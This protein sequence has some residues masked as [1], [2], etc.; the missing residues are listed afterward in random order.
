MNKP[1]PMIQSKLAALNTAYRQTIYEVFT[2]EGIIQLRVNVKSFALDQLLQQ[3][4]QT[5][6]ALI[7]ASN[8]Y[9]EPLSTQENHKRNEA[10]AADLKRRAINLLS[11]VGRDESGQWSPE[12]S[13]F[14]MGINRAD[15]IEIGKKYSQNAILY[16]E[17]GNPPELLWLFG[18]GTMIRDE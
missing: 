10:L 8:P 9:S 14:V 6:Y 16:G 3:Y 18:G 17:I 13:L 4:Q 1:S 11:A 5:T 15:A 2:E 7:T 12:E